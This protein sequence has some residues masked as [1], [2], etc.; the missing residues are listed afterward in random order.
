MQSNPI[1]HRP[2]PR[3]TTLRPHPGQKAYYESLVR[4]NIVPAGR[5]SGKTELAKRRVVRRSIE[6][7]IKKHRVF[8]NG[9]FFAAAPTRDQAKR[10]YWKDLK[11]LVPAKYMDGKPSETQLIIPLKNDVELHVLG[12]DKPERFEGSPWD[13]G[14]LDEYGNMKEEAWME[15]IFPALADRSG[16]CDLIGVPE[17][18]NHYYK[19]Y[20][21]ALSDEYPDMMAHHWKSSDILPDYEIAIAKRMLDE[22]SYRQEYEAEF[23]NFTGRAYYSF[24]EKTH[25]RAL[26]QFYNPNNTLVLCFDFNVTPGVAAI[27]QEMILPGVFES[28]PDPVRFGF[29]VD[30]WARAFKEGESA[31]AFVP[32]T[33]TAVIGEVYIPQ[34]SNTEIVCNKIIHDWGTH[35]G[36]I[37]AYGD[38]TGGSKGSAKLEGSDWDIIENRLFAHFGPRFE[39]NVPNANPTE[40]ARVNAV[41]VRLMSQDKVPRMLV[42]P[43]HAPH[44]VDDFE[45]VRTVEGGS[46]EID[47]KRDKLLSHI[48]DA[49]GY[50]II[51]EF[52]LIEEISTPGKI[53]N[54]Y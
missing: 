52:P 22:L 38:A 54:L 30:A 35:Q 4:F 51:R 9:R 29:G 6:R 48:S 36:E 11:A 14:I 3:W 34:N 33:G 2:A 13:G 1:Y 25:C 37:I 41:N 40:K 45:G 50:Y 8:H 23:V 53:R 49:I 47:K 18:R 28:I 39:L 46:G 24:F 12:M 21:E 19:R 27:I 17:G 43:V 15:N 10:I 26:R 16:W 5:R 31:F 32:V 7:S 42:D 44:V 20:R